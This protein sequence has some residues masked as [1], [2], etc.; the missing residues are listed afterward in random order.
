[1]RKEVVY[2]SGIIIVTLL[3]LALGLPINHLLDAFISSSKSE[4]LAK[5][6]NRLIIAVVLVWIIGKLELKRF[7]AI[8]KTFSVS[9]KWILVPLFILVCMGMAANWNLYT[10]ADTD[11]MVLFGLSA[12]LVGFTEEACFRGAVLP[13]FIKRFEAHRYV[14]MKSVFGSAIVFGFI[15]FLNLIHQPENFWGITS[16][17]LFA[18][19]IGTFLGGLMLRT[20][21][22]LIV[23]LMHAATNFIL[24]TGILREQQSASSETINQ[25]IN[26]DLAS[27]LISI[28]ILIVIIAAG[29]FMLKEVDKKAIID[30]ASDVKI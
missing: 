7:N 12:L 15:H 17:V 23:A 9:D 10:E 26:F 5:I 28:T 1:M 8:S 27:N 29:L 3:L 22:I 16:Q 21:N 11:L 30:K 4:L 25:N 18:F 19:G 2:I 13:L 24:G 14:L 6:V 20:Q